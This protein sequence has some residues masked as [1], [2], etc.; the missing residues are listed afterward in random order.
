MNNTKTKNGTIASENSMDFLLL[1][2]KINAL[3]AEIMVLAR[4]Q[5]EKSKEVQRALTGQCSEQ[6]KLW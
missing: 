6:L 3:A 2:A 4:Q 1:A 5:A